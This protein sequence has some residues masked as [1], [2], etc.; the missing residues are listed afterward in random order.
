[1]K[2]LKRYYTPINKNSSWQMKDSD[3]CPD[4]K[5][6]F[7]VLGDKELNRVQIS[8]NLVLKG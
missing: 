1:M 5:S 8:S 3:I 4:Q 7:A 2:K 6:N